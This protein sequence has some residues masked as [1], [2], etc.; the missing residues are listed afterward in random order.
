M[1]DEE[2][3]DLLIE[4]LPLWTAR[5]AIQDYDRGAHNDDL[6]ALGICPK[7]HFGAELIKA[8][9]ISENS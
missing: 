3:H 6:E 9:E 7:C 8:E 5:E 4:V 1:T 2:V